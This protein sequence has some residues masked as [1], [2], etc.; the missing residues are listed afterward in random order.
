MGRDT[1][2][3]IV[4]L[5]AEEH[6]LLRQLAVDVTDPDDDGWAFVVWSDRIV[7]H[8][9]GEEL[10]VYPVLLSSSGGAAVADSCLEEQ[11]AIEKRLVAVGR[12]TP[13]TPQFRLAAAAL[14]LDHLAHLGMEDAQVLP[15][16][17]TRVTRR[18]RLELGRRYLEVTGPAPLAPLSGGVRVTTGRT[19]I[20]RTEALSTWLRDVAASSGLAG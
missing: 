1:D 5:L 6:R 10:V 15:I 14:V 8:E 16:L 4:E 11:T 9:I 17:S 18:R 7:R 19:V 2:I 3:D 13:G 12:L 20:D